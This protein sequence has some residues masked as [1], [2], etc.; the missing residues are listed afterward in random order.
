MIVPNAEL[1][2]F[3]RLEPRRTLAA[4]AAAAEEARQQ[5]LA[6]DERLERTAAEL[7]R[8]VLS[9]LGV[10][11]PQPGQSP[12]E[13]LVGQTLVIVYAGAEHSRPSIDWRTIEKAA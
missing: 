6:A 2:Q 4:L 10:P 5:V 11:A 1:E 9:Q 7:E 13:V 8:A 3:P 12:V